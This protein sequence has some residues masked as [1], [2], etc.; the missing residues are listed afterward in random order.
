MYLTVMKCDDV[1]LLSF[2]RRDVV[3]FKLFVCS[4]VKKKPVE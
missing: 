2:P 3:Y 1:L 4:G